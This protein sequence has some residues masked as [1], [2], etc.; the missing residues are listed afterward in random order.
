MEGIDR[1][2]V[3]IASVDLHSHGFSSSTEPLAFGETPVKPGA[4]T[5][6]RNAKTIDIKKFEFH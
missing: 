4:M 5:S 1:V 3:G 2:I 6:C